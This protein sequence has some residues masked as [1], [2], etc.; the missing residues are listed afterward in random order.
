[1]LSLQFPLINIS[2]CAFVHSQYDS[3]YMAES[4]ILTVLPS[5]HNSTEL[6]VANTIALWRICE[7]MR[8]KNDA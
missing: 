1:M 5:K 6:T 7:S 2:A 8:T 3:K 4:Y